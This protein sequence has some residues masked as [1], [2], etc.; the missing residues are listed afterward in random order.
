V[1]GVITIIGW[2]GGSVEGPEPSYKETVVNVF[3]ARGVFVGSRD[4]MERM[5]KAIEAHDIHPV[6][7]EK[8]FTLEQ[9]REAYQHQHEQKHVGKVCI[10]ID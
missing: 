10:R 7:D 2:V 9:L 5:I 8:V 1:D 6:V 3:T 4:Q